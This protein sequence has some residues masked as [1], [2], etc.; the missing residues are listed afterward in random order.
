M[1]THIAAPAEPA[2]L[3]PMRRV[4]KGVDR[5]AGARRRV[6]P[7]AARSAGERRVAATHEAACQEACA[8]VH[9]RVRGGGV[10]RGGRR[11]ERR[12]RRRVKRQ[13]G[14]RAVGRA[15]RHAVGGMY[16]YRR[17]RGGVPSQ[18][19]GVICAQR[20]RGGVQAGAWDDREQAACHRR[21]H[22]RR[23]GGGRSHRQCARRP[24]L[25]SAPQYWH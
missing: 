20:G 25:R 6:V 1:H 7:R 2:A 16:G 12:G 14:G 22:P 4:A 23:S 3:Q 8:C 11:V 18:A 19:E 10:G 5:R 9:V 17:G 24:C 13:G 21:R 15:W